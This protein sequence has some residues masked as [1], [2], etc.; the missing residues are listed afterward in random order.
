MSVKVI[1]AAFPRLR[2]LTHIRLLP[3]PVE[4]SDKL[5]QVEE[6]IHFHP[7]MV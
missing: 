1:K 4:R 2:V 7:N 6:I 3:P 5:E